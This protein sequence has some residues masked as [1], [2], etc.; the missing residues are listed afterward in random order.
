MGEAFPKDVPA[1]DGYIF[2]GW[3]KSNADTMPNFFKD[4]V[5]PDD[6]DVYAVWKDQGSIDDPVTVWFDRNGGSSIIG[7][8]EKKP[9][10]AIMPITQLMIKTIIGNTKS[11][12]LPLGLLSMASEEAYGRSSVVNKSPLMAFFS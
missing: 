11:I 7:V 3:A 4:T 1:R 9:P 2:L 5:V 6:M 8:P 12:T 10:L